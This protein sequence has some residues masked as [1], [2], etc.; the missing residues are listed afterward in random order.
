MFNAQIDFG[1]VGD[2]DGWAMS[3]ERPFT[4]VV[5]LP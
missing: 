1:E 5:W 3:I 4:I 2:G